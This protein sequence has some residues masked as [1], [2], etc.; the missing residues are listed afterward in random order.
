M[1][2]I[3]ISFDLGKLKKLIVIGFLVAVLA[4]ELNLTFSNPIAFGDEGFHVS[5]AKYVGTQVDYSEF[6]PYYGSAYN[7]ERFN[8]PPLWNLIEAS[9]YMLFGFNEAFVKFL[10]P[11][12]SFMTGLAIYVFLRRLYSENLAIIAAVLAVT[13]PS[14]VTYSVLFYTTVPYVFFFSLA[15]LSMLTAVKTGS[16]KFWLLAGV[17][18]G[19][20]ILA[21][22]AGVFMLILIVAMGIIQLIK[23]RS[24]SGLIEALKTYGVAFLIALLVMS[25]WLVRNFG[26]YYVPGCTDF[27]SIFTGNCQ[28]LS[29]AYQ[30]ITTNQFA[31]RTEAGGTEESILSIGV[32]NYLQF[33]YGWFNSNQFLNAIGLIF[34]PFSFLAGIVVVARRKEFSDVMLIVSTIIFFLLLYQIGGFFSGRSE[35]TARYFL[36]AA[37][38]IG[39]VGGMYWSSIRKEGHRLNGLVVLAVLILVL[40]LAFFSFYSK[41]AQMDNVKNFVPSF[42]EACDWVKQNV[43]KDA[44]LLSLQTYPTRYNCDRAAV[45]E[46]PDKADILLSNNLTVVKERLAANGI[47]HIF[48]QKFSMSS[49]PL[50]QAWPT[51]FVDFLEQNNQTFKKI[52]ENG[53]KYG[54]QDLT[55]CLNSGCDAGNIVYEVSA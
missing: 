31:G 15:F 19:L 18:S 2:E 10:V 42:F 32:T 7:P 3:E 37:P 5:T 43:P 23:T 55:N 11:F 16:K 9:F 1:A 22:I 24:K 14:F 36:S 40:V 26:V 4:L 45:W 29:K 20:S 44:N 41:L 17:F 25:P 35:D 50:G 54:T 30:A 34:I 51:S 6:T 53:P 28:D 46:I 52:Y 38:L 47:G 8:R 33:A 39:I 49:T 27:N 21:N 13:I 12:V 48:V